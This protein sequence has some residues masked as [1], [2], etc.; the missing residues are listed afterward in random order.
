MTKECQ[1]QVSMKNNEFDKQFNLKHD[2]KIDIIKSL[3]CNEC[4]KI[5]PNNSS[6]YMD[7]EVYVFIKSVELPVYGELEPIKLYI[8]MYLNEQTK[9]DIVIVISFHEE[10]LYD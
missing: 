7:A 1:F 2:Q 9:Y 6:R 3:A 4:I 8:K 5:E 10:G